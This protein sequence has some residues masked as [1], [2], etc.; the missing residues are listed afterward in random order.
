MTPEAGLVSSPVPC[1]SPSYLVTAELLLSAA[2]AAAASQQQ[3]VCRG[4]GVVVLWCAV[5]RRAPQFNL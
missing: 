4:P 2:V 3:Q 5:V 1:D